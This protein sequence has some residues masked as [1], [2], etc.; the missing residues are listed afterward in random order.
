MKFIF[1][2]SFFQ[3]TVFFSLLVFFG[4]FSFAHA[5]V[6]SFVGEI[7][8]SVKTGG[9]LWYQ[10]GDFSNSQNMGV[11]EA[12]RNRDP[13]PAR[14]GAEVVIVDKSALQA[15]NSPF[16][17]RENAEQSGAGQVSV[18]VVRQGDT[19]SQIANMFGVSANTIRWANDISKNG[20][21]LPGQKLVILPITGLRHTVQSGD[22]LEKIASRYRAEKDEIV[23]FNDLEGRKLKLGETLI[24]PNG[25]MEPTPT[26][27]AV[28]SQRVSG[29]S[30]AGAS[31][32][33]VSMVGYFSNP[34]PGTKRTQGIHGYNGVDLGGPVG[35]L[36]FAA[37]DGEVVLSRT[38][39]WNG[40]YGQYIVIKHSNGTQTL[41]AHLSQ[42]LVST[43]ETVAKGQNIGAI[44]NTG[45]STGPHLHFE[46]RGGR[47]PF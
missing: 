7:F 33:T 20:G 13:S 31:S 19:L 44:G 39:G 3:K 8:E 10:S 35:T 36:V 41:Y 37:A 12:A 47:N 46:V 45:R 24:I 25:F 42:N 28:R 9:K 18:Y 4:A 32:G 43:G 34:V 16:R 15:D 22:S 14:G 30:G 40:G 21:V 1:R 26:A 2:G 23:T 11:L 29:P 27:L 17:E 6:F 38:S 5:S